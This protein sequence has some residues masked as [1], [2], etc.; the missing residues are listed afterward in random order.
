MCALPIVAIVGRANVGKSTLFNRLVR[1][2]RALVEDRPGV[3]RDRVV[4][5]AEIEG[6]D[7]L[8]IDTGG[9]DP[10][11]E[12]GI[13]QAIAAQVRQVVADAAVI[14]FTVDARAG[15]L[16]LD[17][18]I[19]DLLRRAD[20]TD[21]QTEV[22]VCVNKTDGPHQDANWQEFHGL[23][24]EEVIPVSAEHRRGLADLAISIAERLP[25]PVASVQEADDGALHLALIGRP[26]VGKSSLVNRLLGDPRQIVADEPGTT[27]DSTDVRLQVADREVVLID[28]A[29]LRRAGKRSER[30]ERGSAYMSVRAIE[31]ADL[32]LLLLDASEGVTDQD[33]KLAR[34]ALD[35]GRPLVLV[36]NKWDRVADPQRRREVHRQLQRKLGFVRDPE[37]LEVSALTGKG[38]SKLIPSAL[39]LAAEMQL[40]IPTATVNRVLQEAVERNAP[41]VAGRR[42]A[43]FYYATQV[44]QRP[45]T[46]AVFMNDPGLVPANY[47]R[48][49]EGV[50][51]KHFAVRSAPLRLVLR[52]RGERSGEPDEVLQ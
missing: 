17:Q 5:S 8:L 47:R 2:R 24:F 29:G 38:A 39:K 48:Y 19:A 49:L 50:F 12:E 51:R 11:A 28:T 23:G 3:T 1:E 36:L 16:P 18:H 13:P 21:S 6:H 37:L 52:G 14:V 22:V 32:V 10:D 45:L 44:S 43:R 41:P 7:V 35:R 20:H 25:P 9:L 40:E 31:R 15:L 27:R 4:A 46:I 42:R 33:A 30:L 26:N 34:L